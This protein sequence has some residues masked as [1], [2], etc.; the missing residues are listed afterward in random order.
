VKLG[1]VLAEI[2]DRHIKARLVQGDAAIEKLRAQINAKQVQLAHARAQQSRTDILIE[3][4]IATRAQAELAHTAT[5]MLAAEVRALEAQLAG[6]AAREDTAR[7]RHCE[8]G[9]R[10]RRRHRR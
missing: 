4:N 8:C 3:R 5:A 10:R 1:Q 2:D 7:P 9:T 6:E